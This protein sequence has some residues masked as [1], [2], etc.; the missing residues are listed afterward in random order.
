MYKLTFGTPEE[1][2]PSKYCPT[3]HYTPSEIRFPVENISFRVN[4]RGCV[5]SFPLENDTQIYGFGLQLKQFNHRGR[6]LKLSVNADP[7]AP[8][9]DSHAPVPFFVTNKGWGMYVDTARYAEF[10]CGK[11]MN[12]AFG[13]GKASTGCDTAQKEAATSTDELYALRQES[14]QMMTIQIP[15]CEGVDVYIME[16]DTITDIVSQYNMLSGG[17]CDVPEWGL[18]VLYRCYS[19]YTDKQVL[20]IVDELQRK[21]LP[22]HIIGLE[23]GWQTR[24]YSCSYLWSDLFPDPAGFLQTMRS[25]GVHVNLWEHAFTHPT[26]PIHDA[27][28]P[29]SADTLVWGGLVPDFTLPE[30]RKIFADHQKTLVDIGVD[31]FKLDECDS[32]DYTGSWSFPLSARFPSGMDGEQYHSMFGLLYSQVLM[33]ALGE[34][35]T[36]SQGRNMGALAAPYPFVVYSDLYEHQDFIRGVA[37]APFSGLLWSPELRDA[38]SREELLRRLQVVVFSVQCLIN[39]WY[40]PDLP[41]REF[42]CE[43]EVRELLKLR[44]AL[45]PRLQEAFRLYKSTGKPPIRALVMDYTQDP[46]VAGIDDEYLFCED[47]LV[48]P[49]AAGAGD[50]RDVYLPQGEWADF[51]TGEKAAPGWHKV[52]TEGIPVYRKIN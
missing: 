11:Q 48:A 4:N 13:G 37:T 12:P 24:T 30:A 17:G 47:L 22:L 16:G 1:H 15:G 33:E 52:T 10:Y 44:V 8:T 50:T 31:G 18:G 3:F 49:I 51:F 32:S 46:E 14:D 42:G 34:K 45:M 28:A 23:P 7:I 41:W 21:D 6:K 9:G 25:K 43:N 39:A 29:Y 35:Q 20:A 19:R 2:V 38:G 5:L 26:A 27:I 36:L 40:C